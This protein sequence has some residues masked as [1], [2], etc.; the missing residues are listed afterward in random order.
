MRNAKMAIGLLAM[1]FVGAIALLSARADEWNKKTVLTFS[2]SV[3]IP[4]KILPAGSYTFKLLD[5]PSDRHIVQVFD[6]DGTHLI[7]TIMA[8]NNYRLTPTGETVIKFSE[9][10]ADA[11][12]AL[13][14]WFYPGDNFGQEFVYPKK[15]ALELAQSSK[16]TVPSSEAMEEESMKTAPITAYNSEQNE[17][18]VNKAVQTSP[19]AAVTQAPA[20]APV[21]AATPPPAA[22]TALA[23]SREREELP[24]TG[25]STPLIAL[26]GVLSISIA[27]GLKLLLKYAS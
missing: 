10:P 12:E 24:K 14:A 5:S 2:Q 16:S 21:V 1:M 22:S 7:T 15:R 19:P 9:Q 25:S 18:E 23:P 8:I 3:E 27:F 4:G 13:K 20:P 11:P 6:A 26:L 17:V